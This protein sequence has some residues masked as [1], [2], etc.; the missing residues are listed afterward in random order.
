MLRVDIEIRT[1][2]TGTAVFERFTFETGKE[3]NE[4]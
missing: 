3:S 2:G 4:S 1:F